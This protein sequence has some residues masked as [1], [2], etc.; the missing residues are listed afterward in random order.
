LRMDNE[1]D[2]DQFGEGDNGE[3]DENIYMKLDT[4]VEF[5]GI[6]EEDLK[7]VDFSKYT[8]TKRAIF[9]KGKDVEVPNEIYL[10]GHHSSIQATIKKVFKLLKTHAFVVL[11]GLG[12]AIEITIDTAEKL[13]LENPGE[14][15]FSTTTSTIPLIDDYIPNEAGLPQFTQVRYNSAVHIKITQI[16]SQMAIY[17]KI[18]K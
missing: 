4:T 3:K 8:F 16:A 6:E 2:N 15:T 1:P 11:H 10:S 13:R 17:Q 14:F 9:G 18:R 12:S 5:H 7:N